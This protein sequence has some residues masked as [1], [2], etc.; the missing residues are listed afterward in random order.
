MI[1]RRL[2]ATWFFWLIVL[3]VASSAVAT[4]P[5]PAPAAEESPRP[6]AVIGSA[7]YDRWYENV[8]MIGQASGNPDLAKGLEAML[9]MA[10]A[11]RGLA[12]LDQ[13]RP[14]A[15]A[16]VPDGD[17]LTVCIYLPVTDL[18]QLLEALQP[19]AKEVGRDGRVREIE[20]PE[21]QRFFVLERDGW[22]V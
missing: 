20:L 10:T 22:V 6:V 13:S 17:R 4:P 15:A 3:G 16:F 11:N 14:W 19:F 21:G 1:Q 18:D 9:H 8:A 12:G 7:S 5:E 2:S